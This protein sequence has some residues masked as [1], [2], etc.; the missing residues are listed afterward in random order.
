MEIA[1]VVIEHNFDKGMLEQIDSLRTIRLNL[2]ER[3]LQDME[4]TAIELETRGLVAGA[5]DKG[6]LQSEL[7]SQISTLR[8]RLLRPVVVYSDEISLYAD[9]VEQDLDNEI[10]IS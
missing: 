6:E 8:E 4:K 3:M 5:V 10:P 1:S 9:L 7:M 2:A